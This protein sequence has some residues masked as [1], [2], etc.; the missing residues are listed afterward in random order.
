M[1]NLFISCVF[2]LAFVAQGFAQ[3]DP[4]STKYFFN[5]LAYNPAYAGSKGALSAVLHHRSQWWGV[6]GGP[7]TQTFTIHSPLRGDRVGLGLGIINDNLGPTNSFHIQTDYS[8]RIPIGKKSHLAVGL[9]ASIMNFRLNRDK[10]NP[11]NANDLAFYNA[12]NPSLWL[13]NFGAGIMYMHEKWYLGISAPKL[14][15][16]DLRKGEVSPNGFIA[17]QYRHY[18]IAGGLALPINSN[19]VFKP[20]ALVKMVDLFEGDRDNG[21]NVNAPA[22]FDIDLSLLINKSLW[23]GTAFRSAFAAVNRTS[24]TDSWDIWA[25]YLFKNGLRVGA[26]FDMP[27]N[28]VMPYYG[29]SY[30]LMLGYDFYYQRSRIITPRYLYL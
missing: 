26:A 20:S 21:L 14:L 22:E 13:P 24:S 8:Y 28:G 5:T 12:S 18:F 10:L 15:N 29:A 30:E 16:G 17:S 25:S 11:Q 6:N 19:L 4:M 27:V 23:V 3:Q 1:K 7:T 2:I 9:Q